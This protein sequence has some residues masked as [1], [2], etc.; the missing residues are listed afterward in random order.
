MNYLG[1][2]SS[3]S[4]NKN[5]PLEGVSITG[6]PTQ[7]AELVAGVWDDVGTEGVN[8]LSPGVVDFTWM[9]LQRCVSSKGYF[10]PAHLE[11][12]GWIKF[13]H[14]VGNLAGPFDTHMMYGVHFKDGSTVYAA[15]D[16]GFGESEFYHWLNADN[17]NNLMEKGVVKTLGT[18]PVYDHQNGNTVATR[19]SRTSEDLWTIEYSIADTQIW[20]TQINETSTFDS[21]YALR[22][23]HVYMGI[24]NT[25]DEKSQHIYAPV[26]TY[27]KWTPT[28]V[29]YNLEQDSK[30]ALVCS[31][32]GGDELFLVSN[33]DCTISQ[34]LTTTHGIRAQSALFGYPC[35]VPTVFYTSVAGPLYAGDGP[36]SRELHIGDSIYGTPFVPRLRPGGIIEVEIDGLLKCA[37]QNTTTCFIQVYLG[38]VQIGGCAA[39]DKLGRETSK[40][41]PFNIKFKVVVPQIQFVRFNVTTVRTIGMMTYHN[42]TITSSHGISGFGITDY[43]L[44][45]EVPI[46]TP[47]ELRVV[48]SWLNSSGAGDTIEML[49]TRFSSSGFHT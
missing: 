40:V 29:N 7:A 42:W 23:C 26:T 18:T 37:A 48:A 47:G 14:T 31:N 20:Y 13:Q 12:G 17:G 11:V 16:V 34:P 38:V 36:A 28:T 41:I 9:K 44:N 35:A 8:H 33:S 5:G 27:D 25:D 3:A 24:L 1:V 21:E 15:Q 30:N 43:G 2:S 39:G 46:D 19:I 49:S 32:E 22:H 10:I 4:V 45:P 6:L